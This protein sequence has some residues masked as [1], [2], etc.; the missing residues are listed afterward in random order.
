MQ[1][2]FN[3]WVEVQGEVALSLWRVALLEAVARTGSISA[4]AA[5]RGVHFRVAWRKIKEMETR[6]GTRLVV[7]HSGGAGGGGASLTPEAEELIRRFGEFAGGLDGE[8]QRR[9]RE[10]LADCLLPSREAAGSGGVNSLAACVA[11]GKRPR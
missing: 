1:V 7:G 3:V 2:R 8:V 10:H 11:V 4:A 9:Y 5:E 6:L